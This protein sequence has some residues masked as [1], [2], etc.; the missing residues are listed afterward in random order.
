MFHTNPYN[1]AAAI[2]TKLL[3]QEPG[4][5]VVGFYKTLSQSSPPFMSSCLPSSHILQ[6]FYRFQNLKGHRWLVYMRIRYNFIANLHITLH[7][8]TRERRTETE[9]RINNPCRIEVFATQSSDYIH[10][11]L[12]EQ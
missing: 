10:V 2:L 11:I 3:Y 4:G 9:K 5:P 12:L 1:F 6:Q 7:H 8:K